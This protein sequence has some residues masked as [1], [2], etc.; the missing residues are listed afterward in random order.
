MLLFSAP[1][2]FLFLSEKQKLSVA[3]FHVPTL[4]SLYKAH[5]VTMP[6]KYSF[7]IHDS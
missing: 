7:N 3:Y 1:R 2:L 5:L 6:F 4:E